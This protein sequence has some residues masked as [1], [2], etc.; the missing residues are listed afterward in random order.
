M[1]FHKSYNSLLHS[2]QSGNIVL[3]ISHSIFLYVIIIQL[4]FEVDLCTPLDFSHCCKHDKCIYF[5]PPAHIHGFIN[6]DSPSFFSLIS[7]SLSFS[8]SFSSRLF[9]IVTS[10]IFFSI[11]LMIFFNIIFCSFISFFIIVSINSSTIFSIFDYIF[12]P[13]FLKI[14]I[15]LC[16]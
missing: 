9:F 12:S 6:G 2:I 5:T 3:Q 16:S 11:F 1:K 7:F 10:I 4:S 15:F 14:F 8:F 13:S